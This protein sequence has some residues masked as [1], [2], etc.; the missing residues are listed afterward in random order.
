M[1]TKRYKRCFE[2]YK[3]KSK[4]KNK[5]HNQIESNVV[6]IRKDACNYIKAM[7]KVLLFNKLF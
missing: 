3:I 7:K 2:L 1:D 4:N 6:K 5:R